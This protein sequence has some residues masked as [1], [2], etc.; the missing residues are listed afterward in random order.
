M[1]PYKR[2]SSFRTSLQFRLFVIFTL[3]TFLI[4]LLL[5]TLYIVS[6]IRQTRHQATQL[7]QLQAKQLA[8][9]VRLPLY[10]E[11]L[12]LLHQLAEQTAEAPEI[13]GVVISTPD[14]RVITEIHSPN[15]PNPN[16]VINASVMVYSNSLVDSVELSIT[17]GINT[18]PILLGTV[19]LQR[20]T[21]DMSSSINQMVAVSI[22]IAF[23]FWLAVSLLCHLALR[24]L[25][26]SF[27]SLVAGI[28]IMQEGDLSY[29]IKIEA[30]DEA[31]RAAN[32]ANNLAN[33]LQLRI[34]E[35]KRL[36]EERAEF[37]RQLFEAHKLESLGIMAGGIAHDFNNLLQAILG[38]MELATMQ[39]GA[40]AVS[41]KYIS[42]T[43]TSAK[44]AALLTNS[45]LTYVGKGLVAKKGLNLNELIRENT[46][47]LGTAITTA[48]SF[49]LSLSTELPHIMADEAHIQQVIM[50]LLT[51]AAE[52][53]NEQPGVVRVTTGTQYCDDTHMGTGLLDERS[54]PG[55][56]VFLEVSDTGCGMD[57]ETIKR[58]FDPF[59]TTKFTGRGLGMSAVMG[60]I[61]SHH[62]ALFVESLP[63]VGTTF[64]ALFPASESA[65]PAAI[66][67]TVSPRLEDVA[68]QKSVASGV[69]LIVDDEKPI[70]KICTKM[71]KLCG[72]T[73]ITACDGIDA[74]AKFREYADEIVVVL[75]DLTMP[76]MDGITAMNEI[77]RIKPETKVIIASGFNEDELSERITNQAPTGF[78]RKPYSMA[79]LEAELR[80]VVPEG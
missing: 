57:A 65:L 27:S 14:G 8:N 71:V 46:E 10:A 51:N 80:R 56:Y 17:D 1:T 70:L 13:C 79:Q 49:E 28:G 59:F 69:A 7:L 54:A 30:H 55:S 4:A 12:D 42:R 26:H 39:L 58:L 63:S 29:R 64:R 60:I 68:M 33:A 47:I 41:Q 24:R 74:V 22:S 37:E 9:A 23:A 45:M 61:R 72:F 11:N 77:F 67:E 76:N 36:Q 15:S 73:V 20:I 62:G 40:D 38:N 6:E 43:I 53:M 44:R 48:V 3:L 75:M 34:E 16:D 35:N 5:S 31:G 2:W 50:N 18:S 78:I 66:K 25:T 32:A 19:Q 21:T 52:S